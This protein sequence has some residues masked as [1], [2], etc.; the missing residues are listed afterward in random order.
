M[1]RSTD[2]PIYSRRRGPPLRSLRILC[3]KPR[4]PAGNLLCRRQRRPLPALAR[5]YRPALRSERPFRT[6]FGHR[7]HRRPSPHKRP[8]LG[9]RRRAFDHPRRRPRPLVLGRLGDGVPGNGRGVRALRREILCLPT[10]DV[11]EQQRHRVLPR[12]R[13]RQLRSSGRRSGKTLRLRVYV[14]LGQRPPRRTNLHSRLQP[15]LSNAIYR[16]PRRRQ[17]RSQSRLHFRVRLPRLLPP[18]RLRRRPA[19]RPHR[20]RDLRPSR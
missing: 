18:P 12:R 8:G 3:P 5:Q 13:H 4:S 1:R 6:G 17:W 10:L 11:Y 15:L 19:S 20:H 14:R 2:A 9:A 16:S 7:K